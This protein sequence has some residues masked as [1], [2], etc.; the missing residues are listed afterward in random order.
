M[1]TYTRISVFPETFD[2]CT[3][4]HAPSPDRPLEECI[5]QVQENAC[6]V[7][8]RLGPVLRSLVPIR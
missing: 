6:R 8:P 5:A 2:T 1:N 4:I 7:L 3:I